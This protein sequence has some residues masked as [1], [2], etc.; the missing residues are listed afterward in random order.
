MERSKESV[1][2]ICERWDQTPPDIQRKIVVSLTEKLI[3]F[4]E[5]LAACKAMLAWA[6]RECMPQGGKY[7]GP[8]EQVETAIAKAEGK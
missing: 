1:D 3:A 2:Y 4:D 5:L 7:D 8:W 6:D